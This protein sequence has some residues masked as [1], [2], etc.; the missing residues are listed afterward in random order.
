MVQHS[1]GK[2]K[3]DFRV[4]GAQVK[5]MGAQVV[6][7]SVLPVR[8]RGLGRSQ[9]IMEINTWLRGVTELDFTQH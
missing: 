9:C 8:D 5:G 1:L 6:F 4:L 2:I 7:S 3:Q